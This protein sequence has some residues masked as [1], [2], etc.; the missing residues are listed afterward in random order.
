VLGRQIRPVSAKRQQDVR[1]IEVAQRQVRGVPVA[2]LASM[3]QGHHV[4]GALVG[5]NARQDLAKSDTLPAVVE[6]TPA[7]DAVEI[8][9]DLVAGQG[10]ELGMREHE[11]GRD[12]ASDAQVPGRGVEGGDVA[13]VEHRPLEGQGLAG[14]KA[15]GSLHLPL[16]LLPRVLALR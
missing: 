13:R 16:A 6:Q 2:D 10:Q 3:P 9:G 5:A 12:Q 15:A 14:G 4:G 8:G 1:A 11:G 7:R